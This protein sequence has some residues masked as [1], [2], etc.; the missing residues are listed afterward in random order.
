[1]LVFYALMQ[2]LSPETTFF[3]PKCTECRLAAGE[4]KRLQDPLAVAVEEAGIKEGKG[5]WDGD[6]GGGK[7]R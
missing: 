6:E 3:S 7:G 5:K 2:R 4:F 1:M